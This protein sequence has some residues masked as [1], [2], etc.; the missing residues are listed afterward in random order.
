LKSDLNSRYN[1]VNNQQDATTFL[2]INLFNSSLHIS[3]DI[4]ANPQEHFLTLHTAFVTMHRHCCLPVPRLRWNW[5]SIST[6]LPVL[7]QCRCNVPKAVCTVK[8]CSWG[9]ANMSPE[10]C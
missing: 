6:V 4:F 5:H 10:T 8:K 7:Q 1:D 3:G 9:L 2:F